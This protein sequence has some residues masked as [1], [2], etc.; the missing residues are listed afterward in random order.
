MHWLQTMDLDLFRFIN[1]TLSNPFFDK[2]MPFVSGNAFFY[3]VVVLLGILLV[4]KGRARGTVC[5]LM[6]LLVLA[7]GD[8]WVCRTIKHAVARDRP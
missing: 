8:G 1:G 3:P 6:L 4:C 5:L 2:V 7:V